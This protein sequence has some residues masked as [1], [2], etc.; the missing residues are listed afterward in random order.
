MSKAKTDTSSQIQSFIPTCRAEMQA[1]GWDE[2]DVL[3]ISGDAYV[4]H[5]SFGVPLL[6]RL[7][8]AKGWRV[9]IIAQPDWRDP[10]AFRAMG[11]PRLCVAVSSGAMDSMVNHYTAAKKVR[12]DDAYTPGGRA[13]ARPNR[14]LIAYTAAVKG[15]LK[16]VPVVIGGIEASLRRL[17]HYD[18]WSNKVRRSTAGAALRPLPG[19]PEL[20]GSVRYLS[21]VNSF[22]LL[23]LWSTT[24]PPMP[25]PLPGWS[26]T[27]INAWCRNMPDAGLWSIRLPRR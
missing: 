13:G 5:P 26:I 10:E 4:D 17:A 24:A 20:H 1:R 16:G 6:A 7:L 19:Y 11:P 3:F 21:A 18:Y 15:A 27:G 8:E 12:N 14:A 22:P 2:L 9:G 23:P 25:L